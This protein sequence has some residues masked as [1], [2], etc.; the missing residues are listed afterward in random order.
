ME[1]KV[2]EKVSWASHPKF[3]LGEGGGG[4]DTGPPQLLALGSI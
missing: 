3:S 4:G 2:L 1:R